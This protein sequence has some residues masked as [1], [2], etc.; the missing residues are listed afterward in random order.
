MVLNFNKDVLN[1]IPIDIFVEKL[2]LFKKKI[3]Y[4]FF[5]LYIVG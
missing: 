3:N 2:A 1:N 5:I 4:K